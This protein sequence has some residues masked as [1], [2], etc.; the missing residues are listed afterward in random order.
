MRHV[1]ERSGFGPGIF[2][3]YL[4][5]LAW[6]ADA[7]WW[8]LN[9]D[10]YAHR[11]GWTGVALHSYLFFMA[12]NATVVFETGPVRWGGLALSALLLGSLVVRFRVR[13]LAGGTP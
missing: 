1:E 12:F 5:T 2:L 9:P 7:A 4:F 11:A 10:S 8:W 6:T 3:S 13:P